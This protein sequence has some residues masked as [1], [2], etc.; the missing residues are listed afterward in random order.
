MLYEVG[1]YKL[2]LTNTLSDDSKSFQR[3]SLIHN[4]DD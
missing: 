4:F 3:T 2:A 1:L